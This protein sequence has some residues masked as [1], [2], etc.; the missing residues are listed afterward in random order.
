VSITSNQGRNLY[1]YSYEYNVALHP[2]DPRRRGTINS[3]RHL[4][5]SQQHHSIKDHNTC[6]LLQ[7]LAR[8][9]TLNEKK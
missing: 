1:S 3:F 4:T 6:F 8:S 7:G 2:A 9:Q 5:A